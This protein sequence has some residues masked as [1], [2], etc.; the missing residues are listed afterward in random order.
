MDR[1]YRRLVLLL[2]I[3]M[4][5]PAAVN[6]H[7]M[8]HKQYSEL[9]SVLTRA[10]I[11]EI[12]AT[13]NE[14]HQH[15]VRFKKLCS[16]IGQFIHRKITNHVQVMAYDQYQQEQFTTA[17]TQVTEPIKLVTLDGNQ[18]LDKS[19]YALADNYQKQVIKPVHDSTSTFMDNRVHDF[20][21]SQRYTSY[22][23]ILS[24][25]NNKNIAC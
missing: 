11:C 17:V 13:F 2:G 19:W 6:T 10:A 15:K 3:M 4:C 25:M 18:K 24:K 7:A 12:E 20:V 23:V 21:N 22:K 16:C 14:P 8:S 1:A 5:L 9:E